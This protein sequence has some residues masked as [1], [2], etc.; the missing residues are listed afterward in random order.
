MSDSRKK[1]EEAVRKKSKAF[2]AVF[3]CPDGATVLDALEN[4]FNGSELRG[5]DPHNTYYNLGRRDVV[6]YIKQMIAYSE[7]K[8]E[9]ED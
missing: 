4:E 7:R 3:N 2:A 1:V 9:S 6:T 5:T 8:N